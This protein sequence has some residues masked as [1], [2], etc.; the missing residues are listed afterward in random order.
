MKTYV[1]GD[2]HGEYETLLALVAKLPKDADIIFVGDLVD[3]GAS[4]ADV[5]KFVRENNYRCVLGNHEDLMIS[6]GESFT[7]T[8]PKSTNPSFM[9]S[10]YN[11]G[12]DAT[13]FSYNILKYTRENGM[14][15]E[16]NEFG[17]KQFKN[18]LEWLKNLPLYIKLP[19]KIND[20]PVVISHAPCADVWHHH[21]NPDAKETFRDYA[22]WQRKNPKLESQ[23]YNI[24]GHTPVEFGVEVE[25][26]F[27]NVDTG[28]Y[29]KKHGYNEL[30][31]FCVE[32][33]EVIRVS[34]V[35]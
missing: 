30:S 19:Q 27:T 35:G 12:G 16:E 28:C 4:S 29:I 2:V 3:R 18:D 6:Y 9:H 10:W 33:K 15:C 5:I 22:L 24:F 14:Q 34:R 11:N 31:A 21:N 23:I 7:K 32:S 13:L 8:Y 25:E 17:M 20:K 1:I 26:H